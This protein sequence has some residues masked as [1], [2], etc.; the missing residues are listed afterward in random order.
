MPQDRLD[1]SILIVNWNAVRYL[2]PCLTTI[3]DHVK[4]IDFE[5]VVV[6][7]A[8]HDGSA[9][10]VSKEFPQVKFVQS[11]K[12]LGFA[13]GNN[14]AFQ[15]SKGD[16]ILLLNPDTE[17]LDDSVS[18]MLNHLKSDPT[19]GAVGCRLLNSDRTLQWKYIQAFPTILNQVLG[20]DRLQRMFPRSRLWGLRPLFDYKDR[21]LEAE[22]LAGS[23]IMLSRAV[24]EEV[25]RFNDKYYMYGD[26]VD[27]C[28]KVRRAGYGVHY[29]GSK[30][31][32]HH[33]GTSSAFRRE[34]HFATVMQKE[35]LFKFFQETRGAEYAALYR[36]AMAGVALVRLGLIFCMAPF[37]SLWMTRESLADGARKW[38]SVL[39]WAIGKEAWATTAG[40]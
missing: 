16:F 2:R 26:D 32:I 23:C 13:R 12:N 6:D 20:A 10:L 15:H 22:V 21:P 17:M 14:L 35:A 34:T 39:R 30:E 27:L 7:N 31:I 9:E 5:V 37:A 40:Q 29:I 36:V 38:W 25:G 24:F 19:A 28:F 33:G 18:T 11:E 4:G 3:Y 8:S 1:L